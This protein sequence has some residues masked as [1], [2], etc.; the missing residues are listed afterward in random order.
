MVVAELI[1]SGE[2]LPG[3]PGDEVAV[4]SEPRVLVT[5]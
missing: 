2:P 5:V 4:F 1:K 3:E